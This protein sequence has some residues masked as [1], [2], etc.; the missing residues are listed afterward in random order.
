MSEWVVSAIVAPDSG[1]LLAG[2]VYY[3]GT[4][5]SNWWILKTD[6]DG[7]SQWSMIFGDSLSGDF[8]R[9]LALTPE[10]NY[11]IVGESHVGAMGYTDVGIMCL[12]GPST[13][14]I[15][16]PTSHPYRFTLQKPH[17]NP[18]N[19]STVL[20]Y[21]LPVAGHVILRVYNTVGILV[22]TLVNA[23]RAPGSH[24]VAFDGTNLASGI[25]LYRLE[26]GGNTATGKVVLLR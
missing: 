21:Q 4:E 5:N 20:R 26:A 12:E 13:G 16:A 18:F 11:L 2:S 10:G 1:C 24:D 15:A 8:V 23:Y 9:S 25:Y 17:P 3:L 22:E 19:A 7:D 14:I 6:A